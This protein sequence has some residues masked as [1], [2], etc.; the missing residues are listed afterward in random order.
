MTGRVARVLRRKPWLTYP[1]DSGG[2]VS[3]RACS[4]RGFQYRAWIALGSIFVTWVHSN[5]HGGSAPR[6]L[7]R[8][9][10]SRFRTVKGAYSGRFFQVEE[11][12]RAGKHFAVR[13]GCNKHGGGSPGGLS[14]LKILG[15]DLDP[16]LF[17]AITA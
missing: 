12:E 13:V 7:G 5:K 1:P 6:G 15:L 3:V 16:G 2:V 17:W 10:G 4:G 8:D 9:V 14:G 11:L